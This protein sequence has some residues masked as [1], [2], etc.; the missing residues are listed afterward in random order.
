MLDTLYIL[1]ELECTIPALCT[2]SPLLSSLLEPKP[3]ILLRNLIIQLIGIL[4]V[5]Q[6]FQ[7]SNTALLKTVQAAYL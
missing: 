6:L 2:Q 1:H 7:V 5:S 4:P 3:E